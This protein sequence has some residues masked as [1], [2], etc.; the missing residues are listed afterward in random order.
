VR[1]SKPVTA[2]AVAVVA[3]LG[4]GVAAAVT[5]SGPTAAPA[6]ASTLIPTP[7]PTSQPVPGTV[8]RTV[9]TVPSTPPAVVAA[10][11]AVVQPLT[12]LVSPDLLLTGTTTI[13]AAQLHA[14]AGIVGVTSVVPLD[15]GAIALGG[16]PELAL[17]GNPSVVRT[18]TPAPTASSNALWQSVA[19]GEI[20][21]TFTAAKARHLTL[22]ATTTVHGHALR[23]GSFADLRM[24]TVGAVVDTAVSRELGLVRDGAVVVTAPSR[25]V[26]G[27]QRDVLAALGSDHE[28][29]S[30]LRLDLPT[31]GHATMSKALYVAAA[32]TCPGLSWSILA[33]IGGIESDH[34]ADTAVSSAGAEGP[35]QFEPATFAEYAVDGDGDGKALIDDPADAVYTAARLLC[36]DGAGRSAAQLKAAIFAYN[37]AGWY[38]AAVESL[39]ARYAADA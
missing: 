34:G 35:M 22:G 23:V 28:T 6:A 18:I 21:A 37:H 19:R 17:G 4:G 3:L 32:R 31:P 27:L 8:V 38:V 26:V 33:A 7:I 36:S 11:I 1:S 12:T 14:I 16:G 9:I 25:D 29:S 10:P 5:H 15:D 30:V 13:T 2:L 24:P 39:A 20:S